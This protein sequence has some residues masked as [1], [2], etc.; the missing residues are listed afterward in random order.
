MLYPSAA[1]WFAA[2]L[3]GQ[4]TGRY[5]EGIASMSNDHRA[6]EL[7]AA[8]EYNQSLADGSRIVDPFAAIQETTVKTPDPYWD[9]L[10]PVG[11]GLMARIT[12]PSLNLN[13]PIYHGT[14]RDVLLKGV[15]HLQG[16]ALP[17]G[18][19]GTHAVVTGHRGLPQATLFTHL[20]KMK[21]GDTIDVDSYGQKSAYVVTDVSVVL[22][23]ET[24]SLRPENGRDLLTLVTCTPVGTNTHRI[25]VT[26]ERSLAGDAK[27]PTEVNAVGFPWW[28]LIWISIVI[29]G[30]AYVI[31][32]RATPDE[33]SEPRM[34][35]ADQ[36][37]T[38]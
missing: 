30:S 25:L 19:I 10:D 8:K 2:V 18:G 37:S 16:T 31:R 32:T 35:P 33:S 12:I 36:S 14:G 34:A 22:P 6:R 28:A 3:Q 29:L 24:E 11:D 9:L 7:Q 13:L 4:N 26:A 1:S 20:D 17:V 27:T 15:G 23:T 5:D 21:V 38:L